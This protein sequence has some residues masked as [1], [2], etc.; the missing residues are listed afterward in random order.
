MTE[1]RTLHGWL[2]PA[3]ETHLDGY[4]ENAQIWRD[5]RALYQPAQQEAVRKAI[6]KLPTRARTI[7]D[8]G[9]HVGLWSFYLAPMCD[10][11][12][13]F[14]PL[15]PHADCYV[16]NMSELPLNWELN[17]CALSDKAG[18]V[19]VQWQEGNTGMSHVSVNDAGREIMSHTLDSFDLDDVDFIKLDVE[20]YELHVLRGARET[21]LRNKPLILIEDKG[22]GAERYGE[23]RLEAIDYVIDLGAKVKE[24]IVDD[25]LLEWVE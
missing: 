24:K 10:R 9:G 13:A 1:T 19:F 8:I 14:E 4:W 17:R 22:H 11:L 21:L 16:Q 15:E 2:I 3:A 23:R 5:K 6:A 20:G 18:T 25:W 12:I 7:V